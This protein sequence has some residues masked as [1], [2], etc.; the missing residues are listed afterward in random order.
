FE[1]IRNGVKPRKYFFPLTV[2]F[3]YF[4]RTGVDLMEKYGLKTAA[5]IADRVLCLP[6]YSDLDMTI[7]D[8]IIKIIKQKI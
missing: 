1:L 8:K 2:N 4:K 7:V 5:D 6:I 3:K